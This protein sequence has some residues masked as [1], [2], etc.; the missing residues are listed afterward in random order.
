MI[1]IL[2]VPR[3]KTFEEDVAPTQLT[4]TGRGRRVGPHSRPARIVTSS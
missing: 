1:V 3:R 4:G 2:R